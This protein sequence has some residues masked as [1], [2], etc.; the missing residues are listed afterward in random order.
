V[1]GDTVLVELVV[2]VSAPVVV[3]VVVVGA[4]VVEVVGAIVV[5][6]GRTVEVVEVLPGLRPAVAAGSTRGRGRVVVEETPAKPPRC[7]RV[8]EGATSC[9]GASPWTPPPGA[10][11]VTNPIRLPPPAPSTTA[12]TS[13]AH[14]RSMLNRTNAPVRASRSDDKRIGNYRPTFSTKLVGSYIRFPLAAAGPGSA[15][16]RP[17]DRV[18]L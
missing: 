7:R 4:T 5:V 14:R 10:G 15:P 1:V 2:V 6:V 16:G 11:A 9:T 3:V 12:A 17:P 13:V 18:G 8:V